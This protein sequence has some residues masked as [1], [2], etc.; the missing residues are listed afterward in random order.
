MATVTPPRT[1]RNLEQDRQKVRSPLARLR[2]YIHAYVSL[3]GLALVGLF[4]AL[5]FWIGLV[6]D[7]GVFKA[8]LV[9]WVQ[10]LPWGFRCGVL[11]VLLSG[12]AALVLTMVLFRLFR[13]FSEPSLALVLERRFPQLLGDRLITAVEM[14][15]PQQAAQFGYSPALVKETIHEAAER[16]DEVPV[17]QVFDWK[18]LVRRG[19]LLGVLT[20]AMYL[21]VGGTFCLARNLQGEKNASEGFADLNEVA[22]IWGERNLLLRNTIW[23]RRAYLEI[24]PF[25]RARDVSSKVE[26]GKTE[27]ATETIDPNE[28]RIPTGTVPPALRVRAWKYVFADPSYPEG[29]R[30]L[31]WAD[32]QE[33]PDLAGGSVPDALGTWKP[34]DTDLGLTVDEVELQL[35]GFTIRQQTGETVK[36]VLAT[37][38]EESGWRPLTWSDLTREKL[39]GIPVPAIPGTWDPKAVSAATL[40]GGLMPGNPLG[41]LTRV[42]VGPKSTN[43]SLDEVEK[44]LEE[45]EKQA[46]PPLVAKSIRQVIERLKQIASLR[47]AIDRVEV[48]AEQRSM[49][50]TMRKLVVPEVVTLTYKGL[51]TT[52]T[53]SLTRVAGNEYTGNFSELKETVTYTVRG[54]D[55]ITPRRTITVVERPRVETLESEEERPAY[56]YYRPSGE[57]IALDIRGKRQPLE[58]IRLSVTGDT[59]TFEVPAGTYVTLRATISKPLKSYAI[60]VEAKD[61]KNYRGERPEKTDDRTFTVRLP[62]VRREQRFKLVFEDTDEVVAERKIILQPKD[63]TNPRVR[64]FNPDEVIRRGRGSEGHI[65]AVGCRIPFKGRV[66]DDHGLGRVR[67]ACRVIP[68]DFLSE[69]KVRALVG[70]GGVTLFGP[71]SGGPLMGAAFLSRLNH[72]LSQS[73]TEDAGP[74]QYIDLP[75]FARAIM[76]HRPG[77]GQEELLGKDTFVSRLASK[78]REPYRKLFREFQI[79]TDRW[80]EQWAENDDDMRNPARWYKANDGRSPLACDLPVWRL[81]WRDK[82]GKDKPLRDPDDTR[83]QKR[84][85]I[86]VRLL[87]EDTFLDGELDPRTGQPIPHISPSGETF[88]FA[89]VPENE[90]LSRIAEEEETKYIELQKAFKPLA[91]NAN[92]MRDVHFALSSEPSSLDAGLLTSFVARCDSLLDALKTSHQDVKG[93]YTT[94][95]RIVKEMRVNQVREDVL[96]KVVR[97]IYLPLA[98]VSETQFDRTV[99]AVQVLRRTLDNPGQSVAERVQASGSKAK[100]AET[101]LQTLITQ[102]NSILAA[103]EGLSKLNELIAELARIEKQEEDLEIQ[104]ARLL[105]RRI[106]EELR[107]LEK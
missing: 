58:P 60:S 98:Q 54:E 50:R 27:K 40:G 102:I 5:W 68:A 25:E 9:D 8:L 75:E 12:L 52:S 30:L 61:Q 93:V 36:W 49:R 80:I 19:G 14:S 26:G 66:A 101:Q 73:K 39:G 17:G 1:T 106:E 83:P 72:E 76:F 79:T 87:V 91:D 71:G 88:S 78:Q 20:L 13:E 37:V 97:T 63:D 96:T 47:E 3:E 81:T 53:S 84:F 18:R 44:K 90:L 34:R 7:Y 4:L 23:P 64:E 104:T 21:L 41:A 99:N 28:L 22:G 82:D 103:M 29:W 86:E 59:T 16:V 85:I 92:R 107:G 105:K 24:L 62:D 55:Y 77:E 42:A 11:V 10:M 74:E 57:V 67:Y 45:A 56:L 94:Y 31:T 15:D 69:Q 95:D 51:R 100:D 2:K 35:E 46:Q 6:L 32:L 43:L 70:V 38:S 89:V 33:R 48:T 65:I